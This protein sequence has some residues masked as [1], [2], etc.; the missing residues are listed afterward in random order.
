MSTKIVLDQGSG[1]ELYQEVFD[2]DAV[3]I[4][5]HNLPGSDDDVEPPNFDVQSNTLGTDLRVRIPSQVW[6]QIKNAQTQDL[7]RFKQIEDSSE[8]SNESSD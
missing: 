5:L 6:E 1:F 3:Y 4:R 8:E 2:P 7:S